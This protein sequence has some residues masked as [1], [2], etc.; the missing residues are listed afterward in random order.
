MSQDFS[1][2]DDAETPHTLPVGAVVGG[3]EITGIV[4]EGGFGIVYKAFD[5]TL[6]RQVAL[7]EYMPSSL[8]ARSRRGSDVTVRTPRLQETFDAGLR[9]FVNEARL[10]AHFDH[11]A[12]VKVHQFWQGNR[13]A[14][15]V[16]PYY[17]G[18]T[19]KAHVR[20]LAARGQTPDEATLRAWLVP[21]LDALELMH[22]EQ[23][24]HRDIAP[25]NIL[26][27]ARGPLL[28]DF[29]AA[30]KVITDMTQAL[31]VILKP[32]YAPIEQYGDAAS[33]AQGPWTDL[34]ALASV[35]YF[36]ITGRSP[37]TSV[38]RMLGDPLPSLAQVAAGRYS[39]TFLRAVDAA[40]AVRPA[41]RP[42][43][44]AEFR[45][46]LAGTAQPRPQPPPGPLQPAAPA[47]GLP[48]AAALP[49]TE[50]LPRPPAPP[51]A[52]VPASGPV[53]AA[54]RQGVKLLAGVAA[55]AAMALVLALVMRQREQA[56]AAPAD[57]VAMAAP[58]PGP[59]SAEPLTSVEFEN[60]PPPAPDFVMPPAA[61]PQ[62]A[63]P[64]PARPQPAPAAASPAPPFVMP[65]AV[66]PPAA[67]PPPPRPAPMAAPSPAPA[68]RAA[69]AP[70][71]AA[72][73]PRPS[74]PSPAPSS[75]PARCGELLQKGSQ[76]T[77][78]MD[79]ANFLRRECR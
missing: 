26:L 69:E 68:P 72:P 47:L 3:L 28:L 73:T 18:P 39:D 41:Y 77:L 71:E 63:P 10:L 23:C 40:L 14:Y 46:L 56:A 66:S 48:A 1:A 55:V 79:E 67:S 75:R 38:E 17:E 60:R 20:E 57:E 54:P 6:Q 49:P 5:A 16:M 2:T 11:P 58:A 33:M 35:V 65:P 74:A 76:G 13:T 36:C 12:L 15:M 22:A 29:G 32:G 4:G 34:Y 9:S 64:A 51:P 19:L 42:Q 70:R 7:K 52:A 31:T 25:D 43:D 30:R 50:V 21:L 53:A 24:F 44:V 8:A 61:A 59:A 78:S 62:A 37:I 45:A 27:T